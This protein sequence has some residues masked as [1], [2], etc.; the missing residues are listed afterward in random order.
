MRERRS[1]V[2]VRRRV[3]SVG[4]DSAPQP[5]NRLLVLANKELRNACNGTPNIGARIARTGAER[6]VDVSFGFLGAANTSFAKAD[7]RVSIGQI[8][9]IGTTVSSVPE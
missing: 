4:F 7:N 3:V 1:K 9:R 5:R 6:F 8:W 2:E